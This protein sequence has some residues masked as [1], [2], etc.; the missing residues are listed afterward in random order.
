VT[1]AFRI[2]PFGEHDRAGFS[3]GK[4]ALDRYLRTQASQDI[5]RRIANCFVAV[6]SATGAVAGYY[7]MAAAGIAITDLPPTVTKRLPRYPSIPAVRIGRLAVS[8]P[9]Q[10]HGLG[11]ALLADGAA[12][13]AA[14]EI[15]AFALLV[16]AKDDEAVSFYRHHGF[17]RFESQPRTLFLPLA[18]AMQARLP[19]RS[20]A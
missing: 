12:R 17:E 6:E 3:C 16:D 13:A 5:R 10:G 18:T 4:E 20:K 11:S 14:A 1:V 7:T 8:E 9:F 19:T 15:A 2:E